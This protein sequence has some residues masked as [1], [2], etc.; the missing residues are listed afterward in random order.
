MK[1]KKSILLSVLHAQRNSLLMRAAIELLHGGLVVTAAWETAVIVNT[2]FME[3]GGLTGTASDLL[4]LFL[5]VLSMAL[6]CLPKERIEAQLSHRV[7]LSAR[8]ALHEAMLLHGRSSAGAL[9]LTLERVDALDPFFHTVVPTMIAGVVLIPIILVVTAFADPLSALLFL[10]T[11]PIAPFLLFLIG[12]ATRRASER[13]WDKMQA[14]TN[15]FGE[16][17]RAAMT[18][19]IFRRID[20][21]GAHLAHMSH[22]FAEASLS[23]L[24]LAFVSAFALELITTLSIALIAVSIGLRLL[25]GMMTFQTAFFVLIL[26]PLF[27]QPLREGG[28]AFHAAMDAK[29]AETA[30]LPYVDLPS[31]TDGARSQILSPPAVH[32]ENISYRYPL[33]E[34]EVITDLHLFFPAGKSTVLAGASGIGKSTLLLLL[35]GQIAPS[36]GK[37]VLSD[38]AGE[39][40]SFDLAQLS[41][42]TRTHLITYVP[43]EPHIFTATLAENVSLWLEDAT[44][45]AVTAALEAAALDDFLHALPEGLRTPLGAGGHPL[46]AGE[47]HRLGLARAFFQNRPIV[48]LDEITAGLDGDTEALVIDALT[49]FAHHRTL[50]LTSHRP[51]LIAWA[52]RVI[53]LGGGDV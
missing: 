14:L 22:S 34:E 21:E 42:K 26:A 38:G 12:K 50:I 29:T 24:R 35:A 3:H 15:G 46:S 30:L 36:E 28:I 16:L 49:R 19:K 37:I 51:A 8:T 43:Q 45:E 39:G 40:N 11:L 20:A 7:R 4:M 41:E 23:V 25:D 53:T 2:V 10:V 18:L 52:D 47:R 33:T 31:P 32:T 44:D 1:K 6:L 48:L 5:C 17:V 13:Q 27:Y 9:T